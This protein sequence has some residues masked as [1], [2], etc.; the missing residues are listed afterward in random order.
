MNS[1]LLYIAF[2]VL[3]FAIASKAQESEADSVIYIDEAYLS[4]SLEENPPTIDQINS[5][6]Y[7]TQA[8]EKQIDDRFNTNLSANANYLNTEE[9]QFATFIPVTSPVRNYDL[10]VS[11]NFSN[12]V[13]VGLRGFSEQFSNNFVSD[14]S[15][16]GVS[17]QLGVNLW[18]D[19]L[20]K[21]TRSQLEQ[22]REGTNQAK[23]QKEIAIAEFK[24]SV[25]KIY[26][27]L[28]ANAEALKI[29]E[30]LLKSST[31]Q[32]G[33]AKKRKKNN[34]ADSGEVARYQS[35][36]SARKANIISLK[37]ERASIIKTLK[38]LLP[39][40]SLKDI[41]LKPYDI[42]A[43]VG[44]VLSCTQTIASQGAPPMKFTRYDEIVS[45]LDRQEQLE[46]KVNNSYDDID[47]NLQS[48]YGFKGR[49]NSGS[50]SFSDLGSDGRKNYAVGLTLNIPLENKKKT[51][52]EILQK[53]TRL[54]FRS[55]KQRELAKVKAFHT[56]TVQQISLLREIIKNQKD[57][58]KYLGVSLKTSKRKYNQARLTVEQL[59]Q[60]QD[61]YLQSNLDEIR[62]KLAVINTIFDYLSVYTDTPCSLNRI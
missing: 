44:E 38:E 29:S 50:D 57:N 1:R 42:D 61:A 39:S 43:T 19:L 34:I 45:S 47:V 24:N 6:F 13:T 33:E 35:Q 15:T 27:N 53:A 12:G 5:A 14:A 48:E 11:R 8:R 20:S 55:Q 54:R 22:A 23:W 2:V 31:R 17:V 49:A 28:V 30:G 3:F 21:R 25:R 9:K 4:K 32:V 41:K 10:T 56:Q 46:K 60:E 62:T 59:V 18:K 36:V 52:R 37:Y 40:I 26:W 16:T 58:T 51:T 7:G